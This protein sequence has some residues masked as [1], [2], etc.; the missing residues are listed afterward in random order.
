MS[1]EVFDLWPRALGRSDFLVS[2]SNEAAIGWIDR[3]PAWPMPVLL[4]HGPPGCGKTH[5]VQVWRRRADAEIVS[6]DR[7]D[8]ACVASLLAPAKRPIAIDDA[9][10]S[11]ERALL[12]LYNTC[13]EGGGSLLLTSRRPPGQW[14]AGLDDLRS[15]LRASAAVGIEAPD[16]ALLGAVL[17]KHFADRRVPVTPELIRYVMERIERSFAA[18]RAAAAALDRAALSQHRPITVAL[19]RR[20][21]DQSLSPGSDSGM[22]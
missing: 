10:R 19:A 5:L 16:D 15:R 1:Q 22:T 18:V 6:G 11:S 4:L 14:R 21:L 12:H 9:D 13:I 2:G 8:E 7:L 17:I 20:V 3:W